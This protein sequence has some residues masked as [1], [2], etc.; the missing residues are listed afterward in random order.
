MATGGHFASPMHQRIA[1]LHAKGG[2]HKQDPIRAALKS[3]DKFFPPKQNL[4]R[5]GNTR[6]GPKNEIQT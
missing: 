4:T 2:R 5:L 1:S 3:V 6:G